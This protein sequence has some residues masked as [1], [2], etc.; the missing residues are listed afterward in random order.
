[1]LQRSDRSEAPWKCHRPSE[2]WES[3]MQRTPSWTRQMSWASLWMKSS[4][5]KRAR[6]RKSW[7][8]RM[9]PTWHNTLVSCSCQHLWVGLLRL[10][11]WYIG[12]SHISIC[13]GG[14]EPDPLLQSLGFLKTQGQTWTRQPAISSSSYYLFIHVHTICIIFVSY[15]YLFFIFFQVDLCCPQRRKVPGLTMR[16]ST[17]EHGSQWVVFQAIVD[18]YIRTLKY[19][20]VFEQQFL[21]FSGAWVISNGAN[22]CTLSCVLDTHLY[23]SFPSLSQSQW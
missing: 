23:H 1:M 4:R 2:S 22:T 10:R 12:T 19:I 6:A 20:H 14:P 17:S 9:S 13:R 7:I 3:G 21:I 16:T 11:L 18:S 8:L 5:W 15:L